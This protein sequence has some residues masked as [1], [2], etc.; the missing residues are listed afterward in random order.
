MK[1]LLDIEQACAILKVERRTVERLVKRGKLKRRKIG[2]RVRFRESDL[3][4]YI[5]SSADSSD[6]KG[7]EEMQ[8]PEDKSCH[9]STQEK[10]VPIGGRV[11]LEKAVERLNNLQK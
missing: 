11:S 7:A 2:G 8:Q 3:D 5:E 10:I 4:E 1:P 6:N 9:P